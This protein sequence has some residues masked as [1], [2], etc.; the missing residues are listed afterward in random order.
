[1]WQF[2]LSLQ[3]GEDREF[4]PMLCQKHPT[5]DLAPYKTDAAVL[6]FHADFDYLPSNVLQRLMA[7]FT[8]PFPPPSC[9]CSSAAYRGLGRSIPTG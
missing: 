7:A 5:P 1:M 3:I 9:S 8:S 2:G 4:I 6:E